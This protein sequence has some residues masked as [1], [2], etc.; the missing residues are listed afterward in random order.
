MDDRLSH[1]F[2]SCFFS[3]LQLHEAARYGHL[4]TVQYLIDSGASINAL[5]GTGSTPLREAIDEQ[6]EDHEVVKL[7]TK[8]GAEDRGGPKDGHLE[9]GFYQSADDDEY[10]DHDDEYDSTPAIVT[11]QVPSI[12][13]PEDD[14][15]L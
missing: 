13:D 9:E 15:E 2:G 3:C 8:L 10:E 12:V 7:L 5:T 11:D 6:G 4:E 14:E 1:T